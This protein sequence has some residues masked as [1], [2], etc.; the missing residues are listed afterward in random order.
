MDN[1]LLKYLAFVKT[2]DTGSFTKAAASLNYAQ[3][4]ISKMVADLEKEWGIVLLQR[5]KKGV[6]LTSSGELIL[7]YAR[8][9]LNDFEK[10]QEKVNEIHE[11]QSGIVRIGTFSSVAINWLPNIFSK[12]QEAYPKIDY[13]ILLGDYDEVEKWIQE[14]RVDCGFLRL[15]AGGSFDTIILKKDEYKAV[16]PI[17]HPLA[18]KEM[19]GYEDLNDQPF[20]LLEHGG[21]TEVSELLEKNNAHPN[22]RFITWEDYAIMSMAERGLGIGIL[23]EMILKRIPYQIAIRPFTKPYFR[24]IALV[25][26]DRRKLTPAAKKFT[27]YLKYKDIDQAA[28]NR[29]PVI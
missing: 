26:K 6:G 3:S 4:S 10:I 7:P 13:E 1:N 24:E 19:L 22:V 17:D 9:I 14:G 2:V 27:E 25:M 8:K 20:L 15:P 5:N 29:V 16:L 11:I 18:E 28:V 21:K 12:F 23:P